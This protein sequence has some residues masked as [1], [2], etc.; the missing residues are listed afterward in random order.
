LISTARRKFGYAVL[1]AGHGGEALLLCEREK[2]PIHLMLTG[3]VM[4]QISGRALAERLVAYHPEMKVLYMSGYTGEAIVHHSV[5]DSG[6]NFI[7]KPFNVHRLLEKV[8]EVLG[9][10]PSS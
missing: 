3:V 2:A 5:L 8:R 4:P 7:Q 10:A 6:L 1:E 9:A